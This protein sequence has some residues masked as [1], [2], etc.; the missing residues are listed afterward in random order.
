M[1]GGADNIFGARFVY[2]APRAGVDTGF[3]H[4][5]GRSYRRSAPE[6]SADA[7][8]DLCTKA[9]EYPVIEQQDSGVQDDDGNTRITCTVDLTIVKA[10]FRLDFTFVSAKVS[11]KH[12]HAR[13]GG[14]RVSK[15]AFI[16]STKSAVRNAKL[17]TGKIM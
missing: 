13:D 12:I 9:A 16:S 2:E 4:E 1:A 7:S 15:N 8:A 10:S 3:G 5:R 11:P 14:Q 17:C 6:L